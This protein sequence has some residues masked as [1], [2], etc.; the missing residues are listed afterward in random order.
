MTPVAG[1]CHEEVPRHEGTITGSR[2]FFDGDPCQEDFRGVKR[3]ICFATNRSSERP[4]QSPIMSR[5]GR[6]LEVKKAP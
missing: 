1:A 4:R 2:I 3:Q 6:R 5:V